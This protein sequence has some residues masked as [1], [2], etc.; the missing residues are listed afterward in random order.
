MKK[1]YLTKKLQKEIQRF[2]DKHPCEIDWR[3]NRDDFSK[4]AIQEI[5]EN[6]EN[7]AEELFNYN[8]D[9]FFNMEKSLINYIVEYF[10]NDI[11]SSYKRKSYV[12]ENNYQEETEEFIIGNILD[13][14]K[15]NARDNF[16]IP[17]NLNIDQLFDKIKI[18]GMLTFYNNLDCQ[19]SYDDINKKDNY[20][21]NVF[22]YLKKAIKKEDYIAEFIDAYTACL[23]VFPF[24]CSLK[25]YFE[26]Q[27]KFKTAEKITIPAKSQFGFYEGSM[28]GCGSV[29]EHYTEKPI[30]LKIQYGP[31]KYDHI[32]LTT[33]I[34]NTYTINDIYGQNDFIEENSFI[35]Q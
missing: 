33:D 6:P 11:V 1:N 15:N 26:L 29:F 12:K 27:E 35:L 25:E 14:F 21:G 34:D 20:S 23:F 4:R 24:K 19:V 32:G 5:M 18:I 16:D 9:Y 7:Y 8:L 10:E 2:I 30:T 3:E 13:D 17:Y 28:H 22:S 31:T